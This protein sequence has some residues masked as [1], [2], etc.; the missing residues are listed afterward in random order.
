M[1]IDMENSTFGISVRSVVRSFVCFIFVV[2]IYV[3]PDFQDCVITV[4]FEVKWVVVQ[5]SLSVTLAC[6]PQ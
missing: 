6:Y 4:N 3:L 5:R 2:A 1:K